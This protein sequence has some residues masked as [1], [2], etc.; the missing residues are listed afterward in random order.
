MSNT[1][2]ITLQIYYSLGFHL[3]DLYHSVS[4]ITIKKSFD[5]NKKSL[6]NNTIRHPVR[7]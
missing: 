2:Y 7:K 6:I 4:I 5:V 3:E 1:L